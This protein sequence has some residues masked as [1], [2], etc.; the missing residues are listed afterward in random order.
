MNERIS[1]NHVLLP[2]DCSVGGDY[3]IWEI[4]CKNCDGVLAALVISDEHEGTLVWPFRV[5]CLG[6]TVEHPTCRHVLLP[7]T[8]EEGA[9]AAFYGRAV[10][11]S[12]MKTYLEKYMPVEEGK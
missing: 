3:T 1:V 12:E 8:F 6:P 2:K 4:R 5:F 7:R 11:E 10:N 9:N